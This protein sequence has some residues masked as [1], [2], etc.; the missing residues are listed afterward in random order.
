[1]GFL[2]SMACLGTIESG[3]ARARDELLFLVR[4]NVELGGG[5]EPFPQLSGCLG[6]SDVY[7][8]PAFGAGDFLIL[9]KASEDLLETLAALRARALELIEKK[10]EMASGH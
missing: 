9:D 2:R 10:V 8:C 4:L 3:S 6:F 5:V 1:M 7:R